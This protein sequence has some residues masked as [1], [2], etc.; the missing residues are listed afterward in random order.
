[1][2]AEIELEQSNK[3][4]KLKEENIVNGILND[5]RGDILASNTILKYDSFTPNLNESLYP[6]VNGAKNYRKILGMVT[7]VFI[8][9]IKII[10]FLIIFKN[11]KIVNLC[12]VSTNKKWDRECFGYSWKRKGFQK[13]LL[14]AIKSR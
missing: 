1:M 14:D 5:R 12:F 11:K 10:F 6:K 9:I 8:G 4:L 2:K 7:F 3:L 13:H